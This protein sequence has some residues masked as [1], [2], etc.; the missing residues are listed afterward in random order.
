MAFVGGSKGGGLAV[1]PTTDVCLH[2]RTFVPRLIFIN[3]I[4]AASMFAG[5]RGMHGQMLSG[6]SLGGSSISTLGGFSHHL[7][8]SLP[9]PPER[10]PPTPLPALP[11]TTSITSST[12]TPTTS[13]PVHSYYNHIM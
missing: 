1:P 10:K 12:G 11:P 2:L 6:G 8:S 7:P 9:L 5:M 3:V 4:G 13:T